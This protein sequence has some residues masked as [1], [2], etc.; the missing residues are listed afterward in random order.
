MAN[1]QDGFIVRDQ[2]KRTRLYIDN[3]FLEK[4]YAAMSHNASL[5][6]VCLTKYANAEKQTCYPGYELVMKETGIKNRNTLAQTINVLEYLRLIGVKRGWRGR[7]NR[8][9]LLHHSQ[10]RAL[11]SITSDTARAV[12]KM[13]TKEY[14]TRRKGSITSNTRNQ[15]I[16]S[17][18]EIRKE[19]V[20]KLKEGRDALV[21]KL[22]IP[23][24]Y[25]TDERL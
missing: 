4:G 1:Y 14:Q 9:Y 22:K 8:Y 6:Y 7:S 21:A 5:M 25:R 3:E 23:R 10:W 15:R 19:D 2:K 24:E 13:G 18:K 12:S 20:D 11:T 17:D 16:N